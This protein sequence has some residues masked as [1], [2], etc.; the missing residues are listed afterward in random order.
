MLDRR[1][2]GVS[3]LVAFIVAVFAG[4]WA[5]Q[6]AS[7]GSTEVVLRVDTE[8]AEA[9]APGEVWRVPI[10]SAPTKG[11]AAALVTVVVFTDLGP[12]GQRLERLAEEL[13][14][15]G[16]QEVRFALRIL[17]DAAT[18]AAAEALFAAHGQG[19][20]FELRARIGDATARELRREQLVAA[21]REAG[22][23]VEKYAAALDSGKP[24][25]RA[26]ADRRFAATLG[27][28]A[29]TLFVNGGRLD[30]RL[31]PAQ[32]AQVVARQKARAAELVKSG[33]DAARVY[34]EMIKEG[35]ATAGPASTAAA[36]ADRV[37][38]PRR[39]EDPDAVYRVDV[40]G[41]PA[42]GPADALVTIVELGDF[43]CPFCERA[44]P[45]LAQILERHPRDVRLVWK[46]NPLSSHPEGRPAAAAAM[47]AHAQGK[48]WPM[49]D[50]LF[51][52]QRELGRPTYE[53]LARE[54]GLDLARFRSDLDEARHDDAIAREGAAASRLAAIGTPVFFVN[55][56]RLRG[57]RSP[58]PLVA[59]VDREL[60]RA[61]ALVRDERVPRAA[62]YDRITRDGARQ[63]VFLAA[64][65]DAGGGPRRGATVQDLRPSQTILP[66]PPGGAR[67]PP[68][69]APTPP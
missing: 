16:N 14:A 27:V 37:L 42:R 51:A 18:T 62:L 44:V 7:A 22:L 39:R 64:E 10:G 24:A 17:S 32:V 20:F 49:H 48:F 21:A 57:F 13:E 63:P 8:T 19:K 56:K 68:P 28:T 45:V 5:A 67:T 11:P 9:P 61:R 55:G 23:D 25:R 4:R 52:A 40:E 36:K 50:A 69:S 59:L 35:K 26:E 53:R 6:R 1:F 31:S 30:G 15:E 38:P 65:G 58:E 12:E 43:Q 41:A 33:I 3:A 29:P 54:V 2:V 46:N 34:A 60:E 47:A 66:A